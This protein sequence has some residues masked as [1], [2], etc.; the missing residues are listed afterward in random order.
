MNINLV[1]LG[2][3]LALASAAGA[4]Q[5]I[6]SVQKADFSGAFR[7]LSDSFT[8]PDT[9][10]KMVGIGISAVL[11]K[12]VSKSLRVRRIAKIGPLALNI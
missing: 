11:A 7:Q 12:A 4:P 5:V 3:G 10:K 8:N 1:E 9:Q 2:A 6:A